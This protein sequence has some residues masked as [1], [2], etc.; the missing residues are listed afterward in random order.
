MDDTPYREFFARP[1]QPYHRRYEALRAVFLDGRSQK[2][3]AEQFGY[4]YSTL[5]QL[6]YEFRQ[7]DHDS[8]EDPPFFES[9]S[10]DVLPRWALSR[11]RSKLTTYAELSRLNE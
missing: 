6:V 8:G 10:A 3:V 5:R 2:E 4:Q 1:T 9:P 7:H 11:S